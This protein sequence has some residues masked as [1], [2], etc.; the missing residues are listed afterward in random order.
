MVSIPAT[1]MRGGTSKGLYF[2]LDDLPTDPSE[3]D[4][5]LLRLMG[6]PD[7]EQI[8]GIGGGQPVTSKVA[9]VSLSNRADA[10]L[11]YLFLQVFVDQSLV[12]SKQNCGNILAGVA[13]FAIEKGLVSGEGPIRIH[14]V[15]SGQI[16]QTIIKMKNGQVVYDGGAAIDGVPGTAAPVPLAFEGTAGSTCGALLPTGNPVDEINGISVTMIDQGMPCVLLRAADLD[17]T[18]KESPDELE[19]NQDLR[20]KLEEVRLKAGT[21]MNLGDVSE[22]SVPKMMLISKPLNGGLVQTRTFIP[23]RCHPTIGLFQAG[24]AAT[25]CFVPGSIAEGLAAKESLHDGTVLIEHPAGAL[26]IGL[27]FKDG[28]VDRIASIRTARKLM[29]GLVYS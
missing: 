8:D 26:P 5:L 2:L 7:N 1:W 24:T 11:D 25:A 27:T 10:D 23:F 9:V 18:G 16:A 4:A 17:I 13:P 21:M 29:D 12:S 20:K 19:Q 22:A 3:R 15:N 28:K 6:S 14:Q